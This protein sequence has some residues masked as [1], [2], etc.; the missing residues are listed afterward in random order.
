MT[1]PPLSLSLLY[2]IRRRAPLFSFPQPSSPLSHS[3]AAGAHCR[4]RCGTPPKLARAAGTLAD[5]CPRTNAV[6]LSAR[7]DVASCA[8]IRS[9]RKYNKVEDEHDLL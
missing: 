5:P 9:L 7:L 4:H 3:L 2:K 6:S 1:R 8:P